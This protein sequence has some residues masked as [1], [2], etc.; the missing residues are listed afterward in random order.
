MD[1]NYQEFFGV[2][3]RTGYETLLYDAM[4]GDSTLFKRADM[5]EAG[6]AVIQPILD[7][8]AGGRGGAL[9]PY[10]AG[11]EG[12]AAATDMIRR[13]GRAWRDLNC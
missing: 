8:W 5:I 7:A 2:G 12:P 1:F 6:W 9:H 13:G 11:S 3:N 10:T 4:I